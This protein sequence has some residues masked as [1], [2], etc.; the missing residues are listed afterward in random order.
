MKNIRNTK[1]EVSGHTEEGSIISCL[2]ELSFE[3]SHLADCLRQ[4]KSISLM[5]M[6]SLEQTL[7][8]PC[9]SYEVLHGVFSAI[10]RI[11]K[12]DANSQ[13]MNE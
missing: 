8:C 5:A 10:E 6:R 2:D 4:I 13:A 3:N 7:A 9:C 11:T 1:S 12:T